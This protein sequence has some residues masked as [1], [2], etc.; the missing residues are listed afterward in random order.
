MTNSLCLKGASAC[1]LIALA[2]AAC[3]KPAPSGAPSAPGEATL[4]AAQRQHIRLY[5]VAS[6]TFHETI[7]TNGVV[8]FDNDQATAVLAPFSGP[9]SRILVSP[10]QRVGKGEALALVD[11]SD[12]SAAVGTYQKAQ[13]TART[14]RRLADLDKDLLQHQGVSQRE[15]DQAQTDAAN[16]EADRAAALQGLVALSVDA[17]TLRQIEQGRA[18]PRAQGVIRAPIAGTVVDRSITPGQLLQAGTTPCFTVANLSR[19]WV[20]AQVF[21]A[22]LPSVQ[23]GEAARVQTGGAS[24]AGRIENVAAQV[25]A[26]TGAVAARVALENPGGLLKKQMYVRVAIDGRRASTGLLVPASA[27]LRDD[28]N[29]PFVYLVQPDGGFARRRVTLGPRVGDDYDITE[30]LRGGDRVVVDGAIFVQFMQDQ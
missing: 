24:Y 1:L 25:D 22:D 27:F 11:S 13:A 7:D 10:G 5:S 20:M 23:V 21:A 16:A 9:V 3:S 30:G 4:T 28:E 26:T 6:S 18:V 12:F 15:S 14:A 29:L 17:Q 2:L 19:V 8:D